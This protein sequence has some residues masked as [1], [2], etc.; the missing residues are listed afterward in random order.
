MYARKTGRQGDGG[1]WS[2]KVRA[3]EEADPRHR[4]RRA[5][6]S[7]LA[8]GSGELAVQVAKL[9]AWRELVDNFE[10]S[11]PV[12]LWQI[13]PPSLGRGVVVRMVLSGEERK[14]EKG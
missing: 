12:G 3:A 7:Q 13:R 8:P 1:S 5:T 4:V 6:L 11:K 14:R 2:S 9:Q 10:K